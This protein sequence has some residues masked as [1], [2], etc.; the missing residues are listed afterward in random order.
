MK[1]NWWISSEPI[2][3]VPDRRY[4]LEKSAHGCPQ[5]AAANFWWRMGS[6]EELSHRESCP[7]I[8]IAAT[9]LSSWK[10][11]QN[12]F[13]RLCLCCENF[14]RATQ[15]MQ[16]CAPPVMWQIPPLHCPFRVTTRE[17][18]LKSGSGVT[19]SS[20]LCVQWRGK[21]NKSVLCLTSSMAMF[22]SD[23][24]FLAIHKCVRLVLLVDVL[25]NSYWLFCCKCSF[26]PKTVQKNKKMDFAEIF[27]IF[28]INETIWV[29]FYFTCNE[30]MINCQIFF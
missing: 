25:L 8:L 15:D 12:P 22:H 28:C 18:S 29:T 4:S 19:S 30:K 16:R 26:S 20:V 24:F 10:N 9:K 27:C 23:P 1:P 6:E 21:T 2:I 14:M 17:N 3:V 13:D 7:E 5:T 11:R